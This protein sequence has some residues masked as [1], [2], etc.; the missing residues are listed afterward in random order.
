[1]L[2]ILWYSGDVM[3][4]SQ[5]ASQSVS[6]SVSQAL[7]EAKADLWKCYRAINYS[8]TSVKIQGVH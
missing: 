2:K 4:V 6:Q 7:R 5:S 3:S 1:M 8:Q